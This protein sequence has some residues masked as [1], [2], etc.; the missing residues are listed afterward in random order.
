MLAA[1]PA[2]SAGPARV[3]ILLAPLPGLGLECDKFDPAALDAHFDAFIGALL[4]EERQIYRAGSA[5]TRKWK[6]WLAQD[7]QLREQSRW[8]VERQW[9]RLTAV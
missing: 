4:R 7:A 6:A 8:I 1:S 5:W 3:G 9:E 2:V